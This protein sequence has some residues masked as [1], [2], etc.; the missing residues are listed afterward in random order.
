M[1]KFKNVSVIF[2][3][4]VVKFAVVR[5][6]GKKT[7]SKCWKKKTKFGDICRIILVCFVNLMVWSFSRRYIF[8]TSSKPLLT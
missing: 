3:Y 4:K 2:L 6:N 8:I 7:L 1:Y 5:F